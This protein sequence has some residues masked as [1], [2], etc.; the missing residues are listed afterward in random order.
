MTVLGA[1]QTFL[2]QRSGIA[3]SYC[4]R[5]LAQQLGVGGGEVVLAM[6]RLQSERRHIVRMGTCGVCRRP[7]AYVVNSTVLSRGEAIEQATSTEGGEDA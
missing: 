6:Q 7:W 4:S 5:C 2:C 3:K 1:L